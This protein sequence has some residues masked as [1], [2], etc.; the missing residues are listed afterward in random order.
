MKSYMLREIRQGYNWLKKQAVKCC[1][2]GQVEESIIRVEQL[3][4]VGNQLTWIYDDKDLS[5]LMDALSV[6]MLGK[7]REMEKAE[8]KNVVFF[9]QFGK[10]FILALQYLYALA[11]AGYYIRYILSDYVKADPSVFIFEELKHYPNIEIFVIPLEWSYKQR[12]E[13]ILRLTLDFMPEKLFLHVK[14]FSAFNIV[15]PALPKECIK[16]YIDLQD[17]AMWIR[18]NQ[19]DYVIPYRKFGATIDIEK[20]NFRKDQV[21][22]IPYYPIVRNI[23]FRGFPDGLDDKVII[24][25]GGEF[26]KTISDDNAY[27]RL[28][29]KVLEENPNA[30]VLYAIKGN[31]FEKLRDKYMK[32]PESV[33]DRL[34]PL[35]FRNDINE[36]FKHC[37][38][39]LGTSPMS[40]GL[41]SQYAAFNSKPILQYYPKSLSS[42]NETEQVLNF[43]GSIEISFTDERMFLKE[44]KHLIEDVSYRKSKGE[45][46]NRCLITK[47]QFDKLLCKTIE[48]NVSQ[49]LFKLQ[50]I[51]YNALT[52]W[53]FSLEKTGITHCRKYIFSILDGYSRLIMPKSY[54]GAVLH[55]F[56]VH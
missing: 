56:F 20:R 55:G 33:A 46:I 7:S 45:A 3:C 16:Y 47:E 53:W 24:F 39:Y 9:D 38:I 30:V 51:N 49:V 31:S 29:A 5:D 23:P 48:T 44:A 15:I 1:E 6:R 43:N 18:N 35:G 8:K 10:S 40:G 13:E 22:L 2:K 54:L 19:I 27:W 41:M 52:D 25:T 26:Y 11:E 32:I 36:V 42:N 34:I 4:A 14:A 50:S 37:D 21:L 12:A 17:H 28:V